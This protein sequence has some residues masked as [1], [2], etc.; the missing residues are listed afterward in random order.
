VL[1]SSAKLSLI[2]ALSA[3]WQVGLLVGN[4][5]EASRY[6]AFAAGL[7]QRTQL[8]ANNQFSIFNPANHL[9]PEARQRKSSTSR[10]VTTSSS[11]QSTVYT[12]QQRA[13]LS[14]LAGAQWLKCFGSRSSPNTV[15]PPRA[16]TD[17]LLRIL[18][19][20]GS[21]GDGASFTASVTHPP[22]TTPCKSQLWSANGQVGQ[23]WTIPIPAPPTTPR[24]PSHGHPCQAHG[25]AAADVPLFLICTTRTATSFFLELA[26]YLR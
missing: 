24:N 1:I 14:T 19:F 5:H 6:E 8:R 25:N 23:V 26:R 20:G 21:T 10:L 16:K 13:P 22:L 15:R 2:S 4:A 11:L 7:D 18:I 17:P 9:R 3:S 12:L